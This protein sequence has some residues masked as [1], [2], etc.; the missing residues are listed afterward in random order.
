MDRIAQEKNFRQAVF[1]HAEIY[2]VTKATIK[3][4][5]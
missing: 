4:G 1:K 3:Y 5:L 2:G